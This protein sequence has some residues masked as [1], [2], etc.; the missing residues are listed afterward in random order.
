MTAHDEEAFPWC[1]ACG[2]YHHKDNPTCRRLTDGG[3]AMLEALVILKRH[4]S[5]LRPEKTKCESC[6]QKHWKDL[7]A[8]EKDASLS[9][10]IDKL[11]QMAAKEI[12]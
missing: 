1:A 7:E 6:G 5:T 10:I 4:A 12:Q 8:H 3:K 2:S 11:R 9:R